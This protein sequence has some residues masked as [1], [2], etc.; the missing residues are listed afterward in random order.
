MS[1]ACIGL[2]PLCSGEIAFS[3]W[4]PRFGGRLRPV[5]GALNAI[6]SLRRVRSLSPQRSRLP[7]RHAWKRPPISFHARSCIPGARVFAA[8]GLNYRRVLLQ[9]QAPADHVQL[10]NALSADLPIAVLL[11]ESPT[12]AERQCVE[13]GFRGRPQPKIPVQAFR[14]TSDV[15]LAARPVFECDRPSHVDLA[16][17]ALPQL[18]NSFDDAGAGSGL[19]P[20]LH[21]A[22]MPSGGVDDHPAFGDVVCAHFLQIDVLAGLA[23]PDRLQRMPVIRRGDG[24]GVDGVVFEQVTIVDERGRSFVGDLFAF[25]RPLVE[26]SLMDVAQRR[27]FDA[28][29]RQ[30]LQ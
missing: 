19:S 2:K 5:D 7:Y 22:T 6:R 23:G 4:A 15:V 29:S 27:H 9:P 13:L 24:H 26:D 10:V 21:H 18:A 20:V 30:L 17:N 1:V 12:R 3:P 25:G 28:F 11:Q 16:D 14:R 8:H